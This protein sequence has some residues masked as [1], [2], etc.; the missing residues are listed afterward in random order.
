MR[1]FMD[2][3]AMYGICFSAQKGKQMKSF[4]LRDKRTGRPVTCARVDDLMR[5]SFDQPR[6][7]KQYLWRWYTYIG[8]AIKRGCPLGDRGLR[9]TFRSDTD[10]SRVV[11]FLE[12]RY[13]S[14]VW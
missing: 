4:M 12:N 7:C 1:D 6:N 14:K 9:D 5:E 3:V 13:T 2:P 11:R 8:E 10:L